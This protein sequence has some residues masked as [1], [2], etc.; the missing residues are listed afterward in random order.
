MAAAFMPGAPGSVP[1]A[2]VPLSFLAAAGGGMTVFGLG[3]WFAADRIVTSPQH[4]G[5]IGAV[6]I[7][8]LAFLTMAVLGAVH[9]F[10]PVV[11]RRPLR[12]VLV[13]RLTFIGMVATAWLLPSGFAHGPEYLV[14]AGAVTG[15]LTV[16]AAAWNVSSALAARDGGVPLVGLRLSMGYLIVTVAFGAV[17][18]FNREAGWF[19]L[20]AHRVL[21]HA[22]L[23]LLGWLGLTYVAVAEKLWPM[24]LL[25]HRPNAR[26][27]TWAVG[28]IAGG[29]PVLATGLLFA[30]PGVAWPGGVA[31]AAGLGCHVA[32][33]V[34]VVRHRRRK[35]ELLHAFLFA[36]T[37]FLV[38][39]VGVAAAAAL[40]DVDVLVRGRLVVA[41]VAALSAWLGLAVVGHAHKIVPFITYTALRARGVRRG[42]TGK[43]L[44]FGDLFS[45]NLA[46]LTLVAGAIGYT[47]VVA[48]AL[49]NSV[50]VVAVGGVAIALTGATATT[51]LTRGPLMAAKSADQGRPQP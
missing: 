42:P 36:S 40:A 46:K 33:L 26:A 14:A 38:V 45:V 3:V 23:G 9:Q 37:A 19:P 6:H 41:E 13:A 48:G 32:S 39:G 51:N 35:F 27:G 24:F 29:V 18:A 31:V 47:A 17:Y 34:G 5:A 28:L 16:L 2:S 11:G 1:P 22:H 25:A 44:M 15:S 43:P 49:V 10:A 12:S 7:G 21:A 20:L 8:M 50:Q 4:P 30:V